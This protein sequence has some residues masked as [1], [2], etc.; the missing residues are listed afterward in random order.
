M[1][2][3]NGNLGTIVIIIS[4]GNLPLGGVPGGQLVY[5]MFAPVK[6]LI[7]L[8]LHSVMKIVGGQFSKYFFYVAPL[9]ASQGLANV[10]GL[11]VV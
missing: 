4:K 7:T 6:K 5:Q 11:D 8:I 2:L 3:V 10:V 1:Y 9:E